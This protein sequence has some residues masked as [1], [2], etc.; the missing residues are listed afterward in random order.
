[1]KASLVSPEMPWGIDEV[2]HVT[3]FTVLM[4]VKIYLIAMAALIY[5]KLGA[6]LINRFKEYGKE[7]VTNAPTGFIPDEG[8][9]LTLNYPCKSIRVDVCPPCSKGTA[10]K[11]QQAPR[12]TDEM[13]QD[14]IISPL[15]ISI[16][17]W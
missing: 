2:V 6:T 8:L 11:Q 12:I 4:L 5:R 10:E 17:N 3:L 13:F 9:K 1:M 15:S 14:R 7:D 16:G